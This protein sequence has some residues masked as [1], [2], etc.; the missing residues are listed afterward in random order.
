ML[1]A[2]EYLVDLFLFAQ[3]EAV[4][5]YTHVPGVDPFG[6]HRG[7]LLKVWPVGSV[8][9]EMIKSDD[10]PALVPLPPPRSNTDPVHLAVQSV[11]PGF[12]PMA[13]HADDRLKVP[14]SYTAHAVMDAE[15]PGHVR[16]AVVG[17]L[18]DE[19]AH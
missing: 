2:S 8:E 6:E 13:A 11:R 19:R 7:Q 17:S 10:W 18:V 1:R 14:R 5:E 4:H 9:D 12:R 15:L 3:T 16:V